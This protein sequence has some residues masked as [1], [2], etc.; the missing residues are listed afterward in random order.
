MGWVIKQL[1]HACFSIVKLLPLGTVD[2][3][4]HYCTW[5]SASCNS[6]SGP[7]RHLEEIVLTI[8]QKDMK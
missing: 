2:E 3:L 5:P 8:L 6:A 1:F 4:M 7:A